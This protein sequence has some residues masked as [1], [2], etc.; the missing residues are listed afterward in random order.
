MKKLKSLIACVALGGLL[1]LLFAPKKGSEFREDLKKDIEGGNYGLNALKDEFSAMG[2]DMGNFTVEVAK[3]EDVKE[4]LLKGKAVAKDVQ[5][6]ASM[7][8]E[9]NYGIT[10]QDLEK[11]KKELGKKAGKAKTF[12]RKVLKKATK[13]ATKIKKQIKKQ[14]SN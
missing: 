1:G 10:A 3:H 6:R 5:E 14:N 2:K 12:V 8:L 4:Y 13:T 7:W 9:A 11:A